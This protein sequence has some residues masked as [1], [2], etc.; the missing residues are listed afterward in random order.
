V[1]LPQQFL[2]APTAQSYWLVLSLWQQRLGAPVIERI[3]T[4]IGVVKGVA[5]GSR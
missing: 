3:D 5:A 2:G 4:R 1:V